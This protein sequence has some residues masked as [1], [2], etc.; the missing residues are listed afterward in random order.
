MAVILP[1]GLQVDECPVMMQWLTLQ[2]VVDRASRS[3]KI[4]ELRG[5]H[6][7]RGSVIDNY[8]VLLPLIAA[9]GILSSHCVLG[10]VESILR[11]AP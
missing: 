4:T 1:G 7:D 10:V 3:G 11:Y 5:E 2:A 8:E 9:Y 6:I